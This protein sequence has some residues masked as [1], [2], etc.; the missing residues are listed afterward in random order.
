MRLEKK[1]I[2]K[3]LEIFKF[4]NYRV[5]EVLFAFTSQIFCVE[6]ELQLHNVV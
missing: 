5:S 4:S 6:S 2:T 1:K 3:G